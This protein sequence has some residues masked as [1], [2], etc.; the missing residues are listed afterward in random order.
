[1]MLRLSALWAVG[2]EQARLT[3][4]ERMHSSGRADG[5]DEVGVGGVCSIHVQKS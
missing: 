4:E 2:Q 3:N 1:M 5:W